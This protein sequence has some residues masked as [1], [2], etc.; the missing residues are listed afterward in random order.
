MAVRCC[1]EYKWTSPQKLN[2]V[3]FKS[4]DYKATTV[5]CTF[6]W[7]TS[8]VRSFNS[9]K[10]SS[11]TNAS[12]AI[13]KLISNLSQFNHLF[14]LH[15]PL[16]NDSVY[17]VIRQKAKP[18]LTDPAF[19]VSGIPSTH[20]VSQISRRQQACNCSVHGGWLA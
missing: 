7:P 8:T 11:H 13:F 3:L 12:F 20:K 16:P 18:I 1:K 14:Q 17:I 9:K 6:Y 10:R 2:H 19:L 4:V 5:S 15:T